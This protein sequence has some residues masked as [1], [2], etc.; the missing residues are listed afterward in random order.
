M[1]FKIMWLYYNKGTY[2]PRAGNEK[3][4]GFLPFNG[5]SITFQVSLKIDSAVEEWT[6]S[7]PVSSCKAA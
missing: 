4:A 7:L 1:Y 5:V 2:T 6:C 3:G